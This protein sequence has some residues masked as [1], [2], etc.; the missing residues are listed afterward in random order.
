MSNEHSRERAYV[1]GADL[2]GET[3][4]TQSDLRRLA[5]ERGVPRLCHCCGAAPVVADVVAD[6]GGAAEA[7]FCA[8]CHARK[9]PL[10]V[11]SCC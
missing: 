5:A 10:S 1:R 11:D 3:L 2:L 7:F 9:L 4:F 6:T 8:A